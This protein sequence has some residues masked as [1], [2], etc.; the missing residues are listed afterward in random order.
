MSDPNATHP[1]EREVFLNAVEIADD[2]DRAEYLAGE[3]G[4]D[5]GL[6]QRVEALL[7]ADRHPT[8]LTPPS[9]IRSAAKWGAGQAEGLD[10]T[11]PS[12]PTGTPRWTPPTAEELD[13]LLPD[14]TIEEMIG[15]GGMGA[16][17]R[18]VQNSLERPVAI[19]ILPPEFAEEPGFA[20]RFRREALAMAKLQH[21]NIVT[22][23]DFGSINLPT[24]GGRL[25]FIVMEFIHGTDLQ[26]MIRS[27]GL[28]EA[29]VLNVIG[30][31]CEALQF[32]HSQGYVHRDIKPAN[33]FVTEE[34]LVKV[35]DFGIAKLTGID[36]PDPGLTITGQVLGTP[37]YLAPE[38][39]KSGAPSDPR[40]DIYS[41]GVMFY[42]MLTGALPKG[43]FPKPSEVSTVDARLDTIVDKAMQSEPEQR[44]QTV[45]EMNTD[46]Q[47]VAKSAP[48]SGRRSRW[49]V[50]VSAGG[51]VIL[52]VWG[53]SLW[54]PRPAALTRSVPELLTPAGTS[55]RSGT[56]Y[57]DDPLVPGTLFRLGGE[58]GRLL[59]SLNGT[60][61]EDV[62]VF[63]AAPKPR[64]VDRDGVSHFI[65]PDGS[66]SE[67]EFRKHPIQ[68]L[69]NQ[70]LR[71]AV[72][73]DGTAEA[74]VKFN[75]VDDAALNEINTLSDVRSGAFYEQSFLILFRDGTVRVIG[76][77]GPVS[78][79]NEID[80][81]VQISFGSVLRADGTVV[82]PAMPPPSGLTDVIKI[83]SSRNHHLA[84][85]K[86]G[87]VV[88]WGDN[89]SGACDVPE[90]LANVVDIVA[91]NGG[92]GSLALTS[93]GQWHH[94]GDDAEGN[95][96]ALL[97]KLDGIRHLDAYQRGEDV[98]IVGL[99][100][101]NRGAKTE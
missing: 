51:L 101:P 4:T 96:Q 30:Q 66:T 27:G 32:A 64:F 1:R 78:E 59:P 81:A 47:R 56:F 58:G 60:V 92:A 3:C 33:V 19:K 73:A 95:W 85:R 15:C 34:S 72:F 35:G 25:Y 14:F 50:W 13:A 23:F 18:G 65:N 79:L 38:H 61:F 42:E 10:E 6:R 69:A 12:N 75:A 41:L 52:A 8:A 24:S 2:G 29:A 82:T 22:I 49:P 91:I 100:P 74:I 90:T 93:D 31:I 16:V 70:R 17:Y 94:W 40:A 39:L 26:Q 62:S 11:R 97:P 87:H 5:S 63:V 53:A 43:I 77:D 36:E 67:R 89:A 80:D 84:L 88:A 44:Y 76:Q 48:P 28:T 21:P 83:A 37:H 98:W 54:I 20:E 57:V 71:L 86:D 55:R 45:S 68:V 9:W 46:L 7:N 99:H